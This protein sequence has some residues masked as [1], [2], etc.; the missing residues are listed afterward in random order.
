MIDLELAKRINPKVVR[1]NDIV[2]ENL[3]NDYLLE[4]NGKIAILSAKSILS[5]E[6]MKLINPVE[7]ANI[8]PIVL[9]KD[10]MNAI[11]LEN[12]VG[13]QDTKILESLLYNEFYKI[14]LEVSSLTNVDHRRDIN[15]V[16]SKLKPV[17]NIVV[18]LL[19][20]G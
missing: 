6:I 11:E 7:G 16:I 2:N 3:L 13:I 9:C 19:N 10:I 15:T 18:M 5:T 20:R 8:S 14:A 17:L 4:T 1:S 12:F